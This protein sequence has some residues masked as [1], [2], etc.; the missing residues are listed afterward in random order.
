[1]AMGWH[2]LVGRFCTIIHQIVAG[3]DDG[4]PICGALMVFG[5]AQGPH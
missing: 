4:L 2:H 5:G 1:M 3:V